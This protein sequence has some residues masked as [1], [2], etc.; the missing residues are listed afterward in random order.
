MSVT[1]TGKTNV[2]TAAVLPLRDRLTALRRLM[3]EN[4]LEGL[5]FFVTDRFL[6]HA[7]QPEDRWVYQL[8]GFEGS[9]GTVVLTADAAILVT[10]SR[11]ASFE[12]KRLDA[13]VFQV[14]DQAEESV[15][16]V[17]IR[18]LP[19]GARVGLD[20]WR[21]SVRAYE[22]LTQKA[23]ALHFQDLSALTGV[24]Q[25]ELRHVC[26]L[27]TPERP[28]LSFYQLKECHRT[29]EDVHSSLASQLETNE[30][31]L[32][33]NSEGLS[34][35]L[36]VRWNG[37]A[38]VPMVPSY[39]LFTKGAL[40]FWCDTTYVTS[41]L[42]E[43]LEPLV[44]ILDLSC[45][46]AS[47]VELTKTLN[48]SYDPI[49][50]PYA[51]HDLLTRAGRKQKRAADKLAPYQALSSPDELAW[52]QEA[53]L[54]EGVALSRLFFDIE[55]GIAKGERLT[56]WDVSCRLEKWRCDSMAYQGPSFPSIVGCGVNSADIHY[57][58]QKDRAASLRRDS[59]LLVDAGGHYRP[60]ATTD[61]S[62]TLYLGAAPDEKVRSLY[63]RLLKGL[64]AYSRA[65]FLEGVRG[66]HLEVLARQYLWEV[67]LDYPHATGHGVGA[68]LNVHAPPRLSMHD[69][70]LVLKPGMKITCEPGYYKPGHFGMR[71]EDMLS[72]HRHKK[73]GTLYF[74]SETCVPFELSLINETMLDAQEE[75]W[76]DAY[77]Q[78][79]WDLLHPL[80]KDE[81]M[82][83]W[84]ACK[85]RPLR[86]QQ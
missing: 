18:L 3:L 79:V 17:L 49:H 8:C 66:A 6:S 31:W 65:V 54:H 56:E 80:L 55:Q 74:Q 13:D 37:L 40:Y 14:I 16:D 5:L 9:Q 51:L 48:I 73:E 47:L 12:K 85:T 21:L 58:P 50:T 72:V 83:N 22:R 39:G 11:Y 57:H 27:P 71:L 4:G 34:W 7:T 45:L 25:Q 24:L 2:T 68:F 29:P 81:E 36:N 52:L 67:G 35:L 15:T 64:I 20:F 84:L 28:A 82:Q 38:Y 10:D 23:H 61:T 69:D 46:D 77:H 41:E 86:G 30:G 63:T 1:P 60:A 53:Q 76:L 43:T 78:R 75:A 26:P 32:S 44:T 62:R 59:I 42:R 70:G 19:G 33:T